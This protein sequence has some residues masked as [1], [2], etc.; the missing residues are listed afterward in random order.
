M[1]VIN[2]IILIACMIM[3]FIS[4][5][6]IFMSNLFFTWLII[7]ILSVIIGCINIKIILEEKL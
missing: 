5:Y 3:F 1:K 7:G 6:K 4:I 2:I